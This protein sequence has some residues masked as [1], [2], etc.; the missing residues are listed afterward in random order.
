M[1]MHLEIVSHSAEQ[2]RRIGLALGE[3]AEPGDTLLLDGEFG[4]GKTVL[5]QGLAA[6]LGVR[7]TVASPSFVLMV[8]HQGRLTLFHVD[9]Y[10]LDGR[11]DDEMLDSLDDWRAAGGVCAIEWPDALP[12]DLRAG[13]TIIR[14]EATSEDER[15]LTIDSDAPHLIAALRTATEAR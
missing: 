7:G 13:A 14:I 10:R 11:L 6:G 9:L 1:T 8:Q 4:V 12:G 3:A 2:T 5:V 15:R